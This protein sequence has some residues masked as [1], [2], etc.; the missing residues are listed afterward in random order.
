SFE[1]LC[2]KRDRSQRLARLRLYMKNNLY[3]SKILPV[4]DNFGLQIVDQTAFRM[5]L[6]QGEEMFINTFRVAGVETENHPLLTHKQQIS[7][8]LE[9]VF[10]QIMAN[11]ALN[12]LAIEVG[13]SWK[14]IDLLRGYR[15]YLR[16]LGVVNTTVFTAN[17]F[18]QHPE[19]TRLLME[20]Y[21]TRFDP[22]L[23]LTLEERRRRGE[24]LEE[25]ILN[26]LQGV[27]S[28]A[29]DS[30]LRALLNLFTSTLRTSRYQERTPEEHHLSFKVDSTALIHGSE[31][32]P[33]RE[34][35]VYHHSVE[36]IHLRGGRLARGGVRWSDR[37]SDYREE[38]LG[39]MR[40]QMVKNVLIVPVGAKGGFIVRRPSSQG[41]REQADRMYRIYI[42]ALLDLTDNVVNGQVVHPEAV[43]CYDADDPYLVVAADKGTAHLSDTANEISTER[44]FWLGD[45][46]AS[47]G[48]HG[49]DHKAVGITALGAW[50]GVRRHF[51]E[52]GLDPDHD[53]FTV[54]GIGDMSGDVFGNSML[55]SGKIQLLAAFNHQHIFLD[56]SPDLEVSYQ[57]RLRL[58]RLPSSSWLD[59]QKELFSE[60]GGVYE[61]HSK[62]IQLHP[63]AR[64]LLGLKAAA[65]RPEDVIRSILCMKVDLLFNG[66]IGTYIK[67]SHED[68]RDVGDFANK[69]VRV[70]ASKVKARVITEGGNLG[71]TQ[72]GRIEFS[73]HGGRINTD[74]VDNSSG[75]DCSDHEVNLKILLQGETDSGKLKFDDRNLLLEH[76]GPSIYASVL[77]NNYNQ[78]LM[79]SLDEIRSRQ[80]L[81]SFER[82]IKSLED[83]GIVVRE[84]QQ[85]PSL[86][87]LNSRHA[88]GIGITR[89]ELAVLSAYG[90]MEVY[91]RL[92]E[93]P[94]GAL[95]GLDD[96]LSGYFPEE[97]AGRY[98]A[99][100]PGHL[101]GREIALTVLT[102]KITDHAG[103]AFFFDVERE[104]GAGLDLIVRTYLL[105]DELF[106]SWELKE[107]ITELDGKV[108]AP[109]QYQAILA[110]E[111]SMRRSVE[112]LLG[113][114]GSSR[115]ESIQRERGRYRDLLAEFAESLPRGLTEVEKVRFGE[116]VDEYYQAGLQVG[117]PERLARV[118]HLTA[119]LRITDICHQTGAAVGDVTRL[120]YQVGERSEILPLVRKSDGKIFSGRWE[121][122]ALRI[123]RN[124]LLDSLWALTI[125]QVRTLGE[126][127]GP[128]WVKESV[129]AAFQ[130]AL[131]V[132]LSIDIR[133]LTSEEITIASLQ[134]VSARLRSCHE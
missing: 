18:C 28:S 72:A 13:L 41:R 2:S 21:Q 133:K 52:L 65:Q 5:Q 56:P 91:R 42:N 8:S 85:L 101:L 59:Y 34:I 106:Q 131:L 129:E 17:T 70:D 121:T 73:L 103:A 116:A 69:A 10:A 79:L 68:N 24:V 57:E 35:Y 38:V 29:Q 47:G 122:L 105:T 124:S 123:I 30:F 64:R 90:K 92:L 3:L 127:S 107:K 32:K 62:V 45:A 108:P 100:L 126:G 12:R 36:G 43:I 27:P 130:D 46:F 50:E 16:Q 88:Q 1:V 128:L 109:I 77:R 95:P 81:Y 23:G 115:L 78:G 98:G 96:Y 125:K 67:A 22:S 19:L 51:R 113:G 25:E 7:E 104:T 117:Q 55:L 33:W 44:G 49:Y 54:V 80:D 86:E 9:M 99:R 14:D 93:L 66:G 76:V 26:G 53:K 48:C 75:V 31:P 97:V 87:S 83:R 40:T 82:T 110:V 4:L 102:N 20:Y 134:V 11:D 6:S 63:E 37:V 60:G 15:H 120:Y 39:L 61:R 118:A 132:E 84:R 71:V 74:F 89:P 94:E 112:W 111:E 58:F 119:G 114:H